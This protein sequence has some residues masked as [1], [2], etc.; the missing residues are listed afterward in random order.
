M[1][2]NEIGREGSEEDAVLPVENTD[3]DTSCNGI[4]L[5][6]SYGSFSGRPASNTGKYFMQHLLLGEF[7]SL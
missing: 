5:P 4:D 1:L 2:I 6:Q 7:L 3:I